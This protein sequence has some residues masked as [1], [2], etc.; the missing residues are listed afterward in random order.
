MICL[1]DTCCFQFLSSFT[2]AFHSFLFLGFCRC[3]EGFF[4]R[5]WF[6]WRPWVNFAVFFKR[7]LPLN[8]WFYL[9]LKGLLCRWFAGK[10]CCVCFPLIFPTLLIVSC[11]L[12]FDKWSA[13]HF[14]LCLFRLVFGLLYGLVMFGLPALSFLVSF[15]FRMTTCS[16]NIATNFF[17]DYVSNVDNHFLAHIAFHSRVIFE[18]FLQKSSVIADTSNRY[19]SFVYWPCPQVNPQYSNEAVKVFGDKYEACL[20]RKTRN[21]VVW[22]LFWTSI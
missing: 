19:T 2:R 15:S 17:K 22:C 5:K 4:L 9:F 16:I 20:Q 21:K 13:L 11:Y 8:T 12:I 3:A 10:F 1:T 6:A 14:F 7:C 18:S